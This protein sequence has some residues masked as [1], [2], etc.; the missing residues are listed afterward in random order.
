MKIVLAD[1]NHLRKMY[2][3]FYNPVVFFLSNPELNYPYY[4]DDWKKFWFNN[5]IQK[6][7]VLIDSNEIKGCISSKHANDS[8]E[9]S[10]V[11]IERE[12]RRMG[13]AKQL[14]D[15]SVN[16][17]N[18]RDFVVYLHKSQREQIHLFETSGFTRQEKSVNRQ[19]ESSPH[20][21]NL[22]RR[23]H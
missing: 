19:F 17:F 7:F 6:L 16:L 9:I 15:H 1:E 23:S 21:F 11:Y 13:F 4:Y 8:T 18:D 22:Y 2:H 10:H 5:A 20:L 3:W 12:Y 14:I